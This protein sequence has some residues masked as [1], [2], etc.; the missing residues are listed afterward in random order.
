LSLAACAW[1]DL[2]VVDLDEAAGWLSV[3]GARA[4]LVPREEAA[5]LRRAVARLGTPAGTPSMAVWR[6][7]RD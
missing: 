1:R 7:S 4:Y 5:L 3:D 6:R 2:V